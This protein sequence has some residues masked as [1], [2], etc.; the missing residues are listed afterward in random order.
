MKQVS[1]S[2]CQNTL[3]SYC[4]WDFRVPF[5]YHSLFLSSFQGPPV[6]GIVEFAPE[7]YRQR[8]WPKLRPDW[9]NAHEIDCFPL[10]DILTEH[11]S[12][13]AVDESWHFDFFSLDVEGAELQVLRSINFNKVSFGIIV[14]EADE[15]NERKNL[16]IRVFLESHGYIFLESKLG[17]YWF[18]HQEFDQIYGHV[19]L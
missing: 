4:V 17:S 15:H 7:S 1:E 11:M 2:S 18:V 9:S 12:A 19:T 5:Y 3:L 10:Q 13:V 16:V 14:L 8:W 6:S